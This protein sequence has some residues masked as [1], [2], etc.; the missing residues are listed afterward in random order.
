MRKAHFIVRTYTQ[1]EREVLAEMLDQEGFAYRER[2][3][4]EGMLSSRFPVI[5]DLDTRVVTTIQTV[6][7]AA[8]SVHACITVQDFYAQYERYMHETAC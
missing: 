8:C 6:T 7:A 1:Q 3:S 2:C 5:I 4:R